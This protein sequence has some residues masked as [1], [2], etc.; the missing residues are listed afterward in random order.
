MKIDGP[1]NFESVAH[2]L[3]EKENSFSSEAN[4]SFPPVCEA[5]VEEHIRV[6]IIL[7][8]LSRCIMPSGMPFLYIVKGM[9]AR[10]RSGWAGLCVVVKNAGTD[11]EASVTERRMEGAKEYRSIF[12][13][14][15]DKDDDFDVE[16][17]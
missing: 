11:V 3:V 9:H 2:T 4:D 1:Q 7:Y 10:L 14:I 15:L 17:Q 6:D 16:G 13:L 5:V 12:S 8:L